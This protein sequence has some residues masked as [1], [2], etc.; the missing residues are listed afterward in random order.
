MMFERQKVYKREFISAQLGGGV[1][2]Y[3]PHV[4]GRITYCAF[5]RELNPQ[6]PSVVLPGSGPEIEKWARVFA[7]Q[8]EAVP[9]FVKQRSNDWA[10]M[11]MYR[12]IDLSEDPDL[13]AEHERKTGRTDI[14][15]VL[16]LERDRTAEA[17]E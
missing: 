17:A 6:A 7:E 10:Y 1:Q 14:S 13:I 8:D 3:L 2:D 9:A 15:M 12:C 11:G 4:D 5:S 16:T